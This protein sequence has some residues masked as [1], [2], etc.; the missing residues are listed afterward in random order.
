MSLIVSEIFH[1]I[2][3]ESSY[4]GLPCTF[5]RLAGC[6]L[7]CR[8][9]DSRYTWEGGQEATLDQVIEA[10]LAYR[11]RLAQITG[12]EPLVQAE[13]P[14]LAS[15]LQQNGYTVLVETNGALDVSVLP[16]NV[17]RIMDIKCPSSGESHR[18]LWENAWKLEP[19]DEVKFVI[20]DRHDYEW[21]RGII[22]ERFG[23]SKT[24]VLV[25]TVF[26]ELPPRKLAEWILE[27]Q[28]EVRLQIQLHKVIWTPGTRGV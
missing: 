11:G 4:V 6:N 25:S 3:G 5:V 7:R 15:A 12:G 26:G 2:Q 20:A 28:L 10:V 17:V 21:A 9:C 13:T 14:A 23:M 1:S 22:G 16:R 8:Y 18:T 27:D 19:H 24:K